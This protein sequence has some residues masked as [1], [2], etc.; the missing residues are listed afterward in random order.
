MTGED[1]SKAV[2]AS[3]LNLETKYTHHFLEFTSS[4][5]A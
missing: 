1:I 2:Y 5:P 3:T 4:V